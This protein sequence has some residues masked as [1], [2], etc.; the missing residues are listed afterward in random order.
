MQ[1]DGLHKGPW[2]SDSKEYSCEGRQDADIFID[3][4]I[5]IF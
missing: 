4:K 5:S 2:L 1:R 3:H